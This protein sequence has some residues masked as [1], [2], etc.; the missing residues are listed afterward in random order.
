MF[1]KRKEAEGRRMVELNRIPGKGGVAGAG[2]AALAVVAVAVAR[3]GT[4]GGITVKIN[5]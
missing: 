3:I 5:G 1:Y 2:K 4:A